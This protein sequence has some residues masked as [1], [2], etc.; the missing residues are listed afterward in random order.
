MALSQLKVIRF[1][2]A[3]VPTSII[4]VVEQHLADGS[5]FECS[6]TNYVIAII[7]TLIAEVFWYRKQENLFCLKTPIF[8]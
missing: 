5:L 6:V 2:P 1:N 8:R 3:L 4:C 7:I